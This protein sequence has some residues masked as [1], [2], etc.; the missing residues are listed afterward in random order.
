MEYSIAQ[1]V[2]PRAGVIVPV[3]H[4][5]PGN[6]GR[7]LSVD[8]SASVASSD[9][10]LAAA[11]ISFNGGK[12]QTVNKLVFNRG[13]YPRVRQGTE[14]KQTL[15]QGADVLGYVEDLQAGVTYPYTIKIYF[16]LTD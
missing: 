14:V 11:G 12:D 16:E 3:R 8:F 1:V 6:V 7:C 15:L 9:K 2:V 10:A 5:L 4:S 13:A